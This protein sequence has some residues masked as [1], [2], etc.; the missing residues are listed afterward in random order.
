[1]SSS[2]KDIPLIDFNPLLQDHYEKVRT[3][4]N[5]MLEVGASATLKVIE[6][7]YLPSTPQP[8][9]ESDSAAHFDNNHFLSGYTVDGELSTALTFS[10]LS[11]AAISRC[12]EKELWEIYIKELKNK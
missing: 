1:M 6:E 4:R 5:L 2:N 7:L 11:Q 12:R 9:R 8:F 10:K 3:L